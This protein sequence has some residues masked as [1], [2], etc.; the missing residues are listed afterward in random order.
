[1]VLAEMQKGKSHQNGKNGSSQNGAKNG[2]K[3]PKA[4][5]ESNG[6]K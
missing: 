4:Q 2:K 5:Q 6:K 3:E 1:M